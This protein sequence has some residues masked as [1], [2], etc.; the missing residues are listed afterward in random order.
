[1]GQALG[2]DYKAF[3]WLAGSWYDST[4]RATRRSERAE[5]SSNA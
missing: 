1:M 5:R 3:E 2:A 4:R